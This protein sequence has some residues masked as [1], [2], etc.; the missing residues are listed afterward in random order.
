MIVRAV[1]TYEAGMSW[2]Q[3]VKTIRKRL[4]GREHNHHGED[5]RW[6]IDFRTKKVDGLGKNTSV[7]LLGFNASR[8]TLLPVQCIFNVWWEVDVLSGMM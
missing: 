2:E 3:A 4:A 6:A 7:I 8:S 5:G 1:Q